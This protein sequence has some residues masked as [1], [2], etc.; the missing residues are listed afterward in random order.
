[1]MIDTNERIAEQLRNDTTY[2]DEW[3]Y[4]EDPHTGVGIVVNH[5]GE[6]GE[7]NINVYVV[8]PDKVKNG[9][10]HND[11]EILGE[12]AIQKSELKRLV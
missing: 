4:F 3:D 5:F 8:S 2:Y 7:N 6:E 10:W 11:M 1:M 9:D 12:E